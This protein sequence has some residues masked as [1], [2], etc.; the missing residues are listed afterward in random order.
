MRRIRTAFT[1]FKLAFIIVIFT[2]T[3]TL[4]GWL[5]GLFLGENEQHT[6]KAIRPVI[7]KCLWIGMRSGVSGA[8]AGFLQVISLM[9]MR[10]IMNVQYAKGGNFSS[11][12]HELWQEGGFRRLYRGI[13]FALIQNPISR[14]GDTASNTGGLAIL[15]TLFPDASKAFC[16][17]ITTS[18]ASLWRLFITPVDAMKTILQVHGSSGFSL[19]RKRYRKEGIRVFWSGGLAIIFVNWA[20]AYPWFLTYIYYRT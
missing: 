1:M 10:T 4:V 7:L 17:A 14:F 12:L 19:M 2:S 11:R 9:W 3:L 15:K 13:E 8:L 16:T 5:S 20:G 6:V 18:V